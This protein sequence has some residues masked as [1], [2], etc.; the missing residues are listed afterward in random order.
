M[1]W[2]C[3]RVSAVDELAEVSNMHRHSLARLLDDFLW[4][5]SGD[6]LNRIVCFSTSRSESCTNTAVER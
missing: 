3:Y 6:M 5:C 4:H 1:V 2:G